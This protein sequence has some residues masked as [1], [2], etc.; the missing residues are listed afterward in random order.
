MPPLGNFAISDSYYQNVSDFFKEESEFVHLLEPLLKALKWQG[1]YKHL[2]EVLPH[3]SRVLDLTGFRNV[4]AGLN[5]VSEAVDISQN[6]IV[7][8]L[9]PALFI[10]H[11]RPAMVVLEEQ[12]SGYLCFNS[13]TQTYEVVESQAIKGTLYIFRHLDKTALH[14]DKGRWFQKNVRRFKGIIGQILF[15]SL[16]TNIAVLATPLFIMSVFDKVFA[17]QSVSL[18][19]QFAIGVLLV[20]AGS[21]LLNQYRSYMISFIGARLDITVGDAILEHLLFLSPRFTENTPIGVQIAK[22]KDFDSIR[23]FFTS[24]NLSMLFEFPFAILFLAV[25]WMLAGWVVIVPLAMIGVFVVLYLIFNPFIKRAVTLST[26][27]NAKKQAFLL[28]SLSNMRT[29][30]LLGAQGR[31]HKRFETLIS[32]SLVHEH[33]ASTLTQSLN[34]IAE[35]IMLLSGMLVISLGVI[36][37]LEGEMS[38]GALIATMILVWRVLAPVKTFFSILPRLSY[39][40]TSIKQINHLMSMPIERDPHR[41]VQPIHFSEGHINCNRVSFR[42]RQD[43]MPALLGVNFSIQSG[44]F[45]A[46]CGQN[47]SGKSTLLK[48]LANMYSV[49][50]GSISINGINIKQLDLIELRQSIAYLPQNTCLFFGTIAQNLRFSNPLAS[51]EVLVDATKKAGVFEDILALPEGFDTQIGDNAGFTL[52]KSIQQKLLLARTWVKQSK[53]YLLDEP[54][55]SLDLEATEHFE[56]QLQALKGQSTILLVTHRPAQMRMADRILYLE[57]GHLVYDGPPKDVLPKIS[58]NLL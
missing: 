1:A 11:D 5:Y 52:P 55:S 47:G 13:Q 19:V 35:T 33:K 31:W 38:V 34:I 30:R 41:I 14:Y 53:I 21:Y 10:P 39:V 16:F 51:N 42:Y 12:G 45:V 9:L 17:S 26:Q 6:E 58:I 36:Q 3:Y 54:I 37:V 32:R 28:E 27:S 48:V 15:L 20:L 2:V 49:Q 43:L 7:G 23:D 56:R 44:E 8:D 18:L 57:Q 24:P 50:G 46:V 22:I 4:M 40:M 25:I 29:I